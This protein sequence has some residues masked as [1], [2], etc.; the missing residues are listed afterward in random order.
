MRRTGNEGWVSSGNVR[1]GILIGFS[2]RPTGALWACLAGGSPRRARVPGTGF[3]GGSRPV[4]RGRGVTGASVVMKRVPAARRG[5][6]ECVCGGMAE[7]D[8]V[9][10][11]AGRQI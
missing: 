8:G 6:Q 1:L 7:E 11:W 10:P 4:C 5:A 3:S 9:V 2:I